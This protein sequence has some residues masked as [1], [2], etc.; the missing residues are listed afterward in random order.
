MDNKEFLTVHAI[1]I[2]IPGSLIEPLE[3]LIKE[4]NETYVLLRRRGIEFQ[5]HKHY[6]VPFYHYFIWCPK[7]SFAMAYFHFG[8]R[9]QEVIQPLLNKTFNNEKAG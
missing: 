6:Q 4:C 5:L 9:Y 1:E 2:L 3:A 7:T 8:R